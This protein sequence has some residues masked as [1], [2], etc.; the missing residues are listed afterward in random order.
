MKFPEVN[1]LL[2][3]PYPSLPSQADDYASD[4]PDKRKGPQSDASSDRHSS[5][6]TVETPGVLATKQIAALATLLDDFTSQPNQARP[7]CFKRVV[8]F[9]RSAYSMSETDQV[10]STASWARSGRGRCC[11][12]LSRTLDTIIN[13]HLS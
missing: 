2:R 1:V 13:V 10:R 8:N 7:P 12:R 5:N 9:H 3:P 4:E 6:P 11:A